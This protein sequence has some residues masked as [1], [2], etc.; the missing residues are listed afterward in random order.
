MKDRINYE[1]KI[2]ILKSLILTPQ[3]DHFT[4]V[5]LNY[6]NEILNLKHKTNYYYNSDI[7]N[8]ILEEVDNLNILFKENIVYL[9]VYVEAK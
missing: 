2:F 8:H 5:L 1:N 3:S 9:G 4:T 6:Q 7:A